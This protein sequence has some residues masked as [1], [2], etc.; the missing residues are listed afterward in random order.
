MHH[1]KYGRPSQ[2]TDR[3]GHHPRYK[4][5][6][7]QAAHING[8]R[9]IRSGQQGGARPPWKKIKIYRPV[10]RAAL[11]SGAGGEVARVQGEGVRMACR[12]YL[13]RPHHHRSVRTHGRAAEAQNM[14]ASTAYKTKTAE[15]T[16]TLA[17]PPPH[18]EATVP[19]REIR[20]QK[21]IAKNRR[22]LSRICRHACPVNA[23]NRRERSTPEPQWGRSSRST[24]NKPGWQY[25]NMS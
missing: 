3:A 23:Q 4:G 11:H 2:D 22:Q 7:G 5:S 18:A 24:R 17:T 8:V 1:S 9:G 21:P 6:C 16:T 10:S 19:W 14:R 20:L 25:Q 12:I 15:A 13:L